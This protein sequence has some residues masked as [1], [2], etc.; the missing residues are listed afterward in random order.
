MFRYTN[1]EG[2]SWD[3]GPTLI[4]LPEEIN[5][6]FKSIKKPAPILIPLESGC[7]LLFKDNTDWSL[8]LG[9]KNLVSYFNK[10]DPKVSKQSDEAMKISSA[11]YEFAEK[12]IFHEDPPSSLM[13]GFKSVT[14][15]L[16][17]KYPKI[18]LTPYAKVIDNLISNNNLREFFYHFS[19]Y[20]G[21]NPNEAQGGI[22]SIAHVELNSEIVFPKSGVFSIAEHLH[23]AA[24]DYNVKFNFNSEVL[25]LNL[26]NTENSRLGFELTFKNKGSIQR[27]N[28][29]IVISNCDPFVAAKKWLDI[30]SIRDFFNSKLL[31]EYYRP[32]ESQFVILFDWYDSVPIDHHVKIF[33]ESWRES[34]IHVC[35]NI[36]IPEDPCVYLVW[37]HATDKSISP[38]VLFISAMAP[39]TLS[40]IDWNEGFSNQ[41]AEKI[42][43]ICR[44]R[45]NLNFNGKIF[46]LI[47]PM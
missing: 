9:I 16:L 7:R 14:S 37:P 35:E 38:R 43:K 47:S 1:D 6:I 32:S 5:L 17:L 24:V 36:K 41:Y 12:H 25:K 3:T 2:M 30:P 23:K 33:P 45:L 8:P 31:K 46:K 18:T 44:D 20:V 21:M 39:N 10:I 11:I 29:D 15:G 27:A 22:L 13:L 19:S 34:F 26:L 4:S 40:N 42:L 28:Y